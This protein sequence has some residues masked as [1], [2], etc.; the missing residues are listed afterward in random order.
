MSLC[1]YCGDPATTID[2][3]IPVNFAS[4]VRRKKGRP[5]KRRDLGVPQVPACLD[6]NAILTDRFLL[7]VEARREFI[8][9]Y[10]S[11][12]LR[13]NRLTQWTEDELQDLGPALQASVRQSIAVRNRLESRAKFAKF[14]PAFIRRDPS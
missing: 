12:Q 7:T 6:C 8:A 14:P 2:H 5:H 4:K 3:V 13:S 10:L 9:T 1:V 11:N